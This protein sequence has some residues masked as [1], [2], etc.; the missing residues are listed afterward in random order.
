MTDRIEAAAAEL[1]PLL[2]NFILWARENAPGSDANLVGSVAL[3]HRLIASDAKI[4]ILAEGYDW[5]EGPV[6][7]KDGGYLLFSDVP[8]NVVYRW[9]AGEGARPSG[10]DHGRVTVPPSVD[11]LGEAGLGR[12]EGGGGVDLPAHLPPCFLD[13]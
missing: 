4:E 9:K 2:Q 12:L 7:I 8:Q 11:E 5:S 13:V 1:R 3:W 10:V 6:W